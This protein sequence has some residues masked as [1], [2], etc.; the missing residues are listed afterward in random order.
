MQPSVASEPWPPRKGELLPRF[1]EPLGIEKKLRNYSLAEGHEKGGAKAHGFAVM[2]GI[3]PESIVYL[4]R[5]IRDGSACTP[6]S[7]VKL[8]PAGTVA[9]TVQFPIA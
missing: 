1:D 4:E 6:I 2:L 5:Q 3:G 7:L 9:C 8:R